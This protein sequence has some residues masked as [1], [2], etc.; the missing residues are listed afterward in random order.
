MTGLPG[1]PNSTYLWHL[2]EVKDV[3]IKI[4]TGIHTRRTVR[5]RR[6]RRDLRLNAKF[7]LHDGEPQP[8]SD[9][10]FFLSA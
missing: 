8:N 3:I 2:N 9:E 1:L 5:Q 4:V 7:G 6:M 10:Q